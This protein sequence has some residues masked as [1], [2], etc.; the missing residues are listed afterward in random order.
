M[1]VERDFEPIELNG[2]KSYP[3]KQRQSKVTIKEFGHTYSKGSS[4]SQFIDSLPDVL[5]ARDLKE[6]ASNIVTA[7][8]AHN[9][10]VFGLGAHVIKVGLNPIIIDL[11][12]R[13]IINAIAL[14]GAGIIHDAEIAMIG[15]TSEDVGNNLTEGSFGMAE[16]TALL[17]N[18]AVSEGV[19]SGLGIGES[20]GEKLLNLG[21]PHNDL[22]ILASGA[23]LKVP[24]TVHIAIG[25]D[26][27]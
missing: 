23:K 8:K 19:E 15:Q 10:I 12:E 21:L 27:V 26:I 1:Q 18:D 17:I 20:V 16:E 14:N 13:G 11:M 4:F 9:I 6:V 3:L 2:I 25:T 7:H 24:V 22:S 5:A